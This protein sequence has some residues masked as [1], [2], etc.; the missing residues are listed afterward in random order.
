M[1]INIQ[2]FGIINVHTLFPG[3]TSQQLSEFLHGNPHPT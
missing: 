2:V 1:N 3:V